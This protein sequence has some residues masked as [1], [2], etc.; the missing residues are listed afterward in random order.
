M[1]LMAGRCRNMITKKFLLKNSEE[2]L[3]ILGAQ[4]AHLNLLEREL[5]VEIF[6]HHDPDA[7]GATLTV[8]GTTSNSDKAL[9]RIK[10][11]LDEFYAEKL[12]PA[13]PEEYTGPRPPP[14]RPLYRPVSG[15]AV[16][17]RTE[18][19]R[20]YMD[21]IAVSDLVV[22][23][24]PAGTG[25]TFL[26][27]AAA[28]NALKAGMV[29]RIIL[30]RPIVEAGEKLG[31]LPGDVS[32]KVHPY[33]KPL[34]DAFHTLL[35]PEGFRLLREDEVIEIVP[36]AYM[37]GRTLENAF[38]ILDEAQNTM[39]EQ[40]KMFLTRMGN[41]SKVV[42]TG[43]IT[44]I[45]LEEKNRSGLVLIKDILKNIQAV[46]IIYFSGRDVVRHPLVKEIVQAY[47]D[48]EKD[49]PNA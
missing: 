32:E 20:K 9:K 17:P 22:G 13:A 15:D 43:D 8:K 14:E 5:R 41:L 7:S 2:V 34:Y 37:R 35:G 6:V 19:Q 33:L 28:L 48:W 42:I 12:S 10:D 29:K 3:A 25:K 47:E 16:Y 30:T 23:I 21:A 49:N 38:I 45:D 26:A 24:G 27:A 36:L 1:P 11:L 44:Q 18:N 46:K 31:F 40:I 39:P 4:D